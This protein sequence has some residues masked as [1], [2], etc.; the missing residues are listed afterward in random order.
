MK[1]KTFLKQLRK[2]IDSLMSCQCSLCEDIS[3]L[4]DTVNAQSTE[5]ID[6]N[7]VLRALCTQVGDIN[8]PDWYITG[9]SSNVQGGACIRNG[10]VV[11]S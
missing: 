1:R 10:H 2:D 7:D 9:I 8:Q 11:P 5:I 4:S 3:L 6:T